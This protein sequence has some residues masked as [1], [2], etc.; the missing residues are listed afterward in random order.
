MNRLKLAVAGA[1]IVCV[2]A[3]AASPAGAEVNEKGYNECIARGMGARY[4]CDMYGGW[5]GPSKKK[6]GTTTNVC[7]R[8]KKDAKA[9]PGGPQGGVNEQP[10]QQSGRPEQAPR[11]GGYEQPERRSPQRQ[12]PDTTAPRGGKGSP[13]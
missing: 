13:D 5:W 6:D 1:L 8:S 3:V 10:E 12:D 7:W 4:C 9:Q 2:S 11:G